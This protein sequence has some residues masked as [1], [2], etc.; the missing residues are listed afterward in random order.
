MRDR[1]PVI[2]GEE[3][4]RELPRPEE[5]TLEA[6]TAVDPPPE[7]L[8]PVSAKDGEKVSFVPPTEMTLGEEEGY[9]AG[10]PASPA[11]TKKLTPDLEKWLS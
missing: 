11:E 10:S 9:S 2:W 3:R 7:L 6:G 5:R 4:R 1:R 8:Q